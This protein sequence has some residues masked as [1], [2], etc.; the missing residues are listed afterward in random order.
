MSIIMGER[1]GNV[2]GGR[3]YS[4]CDLRWPTL[5]SHEQLLTSILLMNYRDLY[6][7]NICFEIYAW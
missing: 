3:T 5:L 1:Y 6:N 7:R 2:L 4:D